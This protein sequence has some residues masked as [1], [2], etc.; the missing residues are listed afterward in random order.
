MIGAFGWME[1]IL[2]CFIGFLVMGSVA[3][4]CNPIKKLRRYLA[5]VPPGSIASPSHLKTLLALCWDDLEGWNQENMTVGEFRDLEIEEVEWEPPLLRFTI[6]RYGATVL[7]STNLHRQRWQVNVDAKK[8][9][10]LQNWVQPG[11]TL[12]ST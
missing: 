3:L 11:G 2:I 7:G 1:I 4:L 12:S 5:S 8:A 10:I 9:I 6:E